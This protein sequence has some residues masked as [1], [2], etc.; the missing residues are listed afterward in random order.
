MEDEVTTQN[1]QLVSLDN[2]LSAGVHIGTQRKLKDMAKFIYKVRPD[3]LCILDLS[4][5]D[6]RIGTTAK[7]IS[8]FDPKKVAVVCARD[9]GKFP[10][11]RFS[12]LVGA[13]PLITRF[14]PGTFTNPDFDGFMEPDVVF[15]EDPGADNQAVKEA[16][17]MNLP[18]VAMC[19][20]NNMTQNIDLI[21]PC[22]NKG[23]KSLA[24]LYWL[25][26]RE[27]LRARGDIKKDADFVS[28]PEDFEDQ[29][30]VI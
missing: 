24:L 22:N 19:D 20:T 26:A 13:V 4:V 14:M 30:I 8:R 15:V 10:V 5:I 7:F 23:K 21:L 3:G 17:K 11:K 1:T 29:E 12:D 6:E 27:V 16:L 2:Y 25:L 28:R 18:I 9:V